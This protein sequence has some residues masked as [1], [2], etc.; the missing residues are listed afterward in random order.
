MKPFAQVFSTMRLRISQLTITL[1]NLSHYLR[2][3][4]HLLAHL[5]QLWF[6][7]TRFILLFIFL[8]GPVGIFSRLQLSLAKLVHSIH[9]SRQLRCS[10]SL[11]ASFLSRER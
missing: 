8:L 2:P 5:A 4:P 1:P 10:Q 6:E 9:P 3:F 7:C 11:L